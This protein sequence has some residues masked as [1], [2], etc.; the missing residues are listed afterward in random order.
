MTMPQFGTAQLP[1]P[2][3]VVQVPYNPMAP[4]NRQLMY[5]CGP[6]G[7][8]PL[9]RNSPFGPLCHRHSLFWARFLPVARPDAVGQFDLVATAGDTYFPFSAGPG[10]SGVTMGVPATAGNITDGEV[11]TYDN[12][13]VADN[14]EMFVASAMAVEAD[15]PFRAIASPT[16][17]VPY[18]AGPDLAYDPDLDDFVRPAIHAVLTQFYLRT[19]FGRNACNYILDLLKYWPQYSGPSHDGQTPVNGTPIARLTVPFC[20]P[21]CMSSSQNSNKLTLRA[22]LARTIRLRSSDACPNTINAPVYVPVQID[23]IGSVI[24]L[25][26]MYNAQLQQYLPMG[27]FQPVGVPG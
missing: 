11:T 22:V 7:C 17:E 13:D 4:D 26:G 1:A 15:R 21:M 8:D 6:G 18:A 5:Y 27:A 25:N 12:G 10:Q 19:E 2:N 9:Q 16:L 23:L 24:C 3:T 14:N 20:F